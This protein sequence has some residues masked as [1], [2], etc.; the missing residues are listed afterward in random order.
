M[1]FRLIL[2][3]TLVPLA[4]LWLLISISR[5]TGIP[6]TIGIVLVTGFVG[7]SLARYQGWQT[8]RRLQT[9]LQSGRTP[10]DAL[11]DGLMIFIAGVLMITPGVLTDS[12]GFA[13]LL[14]PV[15]RHLKL[16]FRKW[17]TAKAT[18]QLHTFHSQSAGATFED[19][20]NTVIDVEYTRTE[21]EETGRDT[22]SLPSK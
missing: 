2:L 1:L 9:E 19:E 14:P 6:R 18:A 10:A 5:Y 15:R 16:R 13:L 21:E 11:L 7:A 4:E 8:W 3:F 22:E 12:V 17:L 20:N